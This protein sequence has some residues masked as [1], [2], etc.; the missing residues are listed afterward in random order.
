MLTP[1]CSDG[2]A[3]QNKTDGLEYCL[4]D[5]DTADRS[6]VRRK[7]YSLFSS[8]EIVARQQFVVLFVGEL[9]PP[10]NLAEVIPVAKHKSSRN[11]D[12]EHRG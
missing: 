6:V 7:E 3:R 8:K 12:P 10:V 4:D 5:R 1:P 9:E 11:D 2:Q